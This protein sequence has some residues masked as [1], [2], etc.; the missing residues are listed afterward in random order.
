MKHL[1]ILV[2]LILI[3]CV[4][5]ACVPVAAPSPAEPAAESPVIARCALHAWRLEFTHP[6]TEE[7]VQFEAPLP[8]DMQTMLDLLAEH[9]P[10]K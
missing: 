7:R 6:S 10:A 3:A 8:D 2:G 4:L 9:R 1:G 5:G